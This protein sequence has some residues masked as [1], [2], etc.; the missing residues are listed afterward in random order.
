[1]NFLDCSLNQKGLDFGEFTVAISQGM[2]S[3][4]TPHG[5]KFKFGIRP[6][7]I[8]TSKEQKRDWVPL[9]VNI[10][11]NIGIYKILNLSSNTINIKSRVPEYVRVSE[12]DRVWV[13]FPENKVKI[14]KEDK[15]VH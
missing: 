2:R 13:S 15:K 11:E 12:G 10:V 8:D 7:S 6:E 14:Y 4:L 3:E 1:M 5:S 9:T